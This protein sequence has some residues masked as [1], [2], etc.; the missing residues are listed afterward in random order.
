MFNISNFE[1]WNQTTYLNVKSCSGPARSYKLA[2]AQVS[3]LPDFLILPLLLLLLLPSSA[4]SLLKVCK[5]NYLFAHNLFDIHSRALV[6]SRVLV[7]LIFCNFIHPDRIEGLFDSM[8]TRIAPGVGANLLGQHAAE[9]NQDATAYVGNL[10][11]QVTI[12]SPHTSI[13]SLPLLS[14]I[15]GFIYPFSSF[16][17]R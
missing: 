7:H 17:C 14:S 1:A 12:L 11:P 8:T 3:L 16:C 5:R 15:L 2:A 13:H 10:D 6:M 9:R 4:C